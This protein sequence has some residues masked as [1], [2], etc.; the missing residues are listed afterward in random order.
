M[1]RYYVSL[2]SVSYDTRSQGLDTEIMPEEHKQKIYN[3]LVQQYGSFGIDRKVNNFIQLGKEPFSIIAF[4]NKFLQ[5]C[6]NAFVL[7]SYYPALTGICALGERILNHLVLKLR[8][9]YKNTTSYKNVY[10]KK[11]F[12]KWDHAIK[13]LEEWGIFID[14]K[15]FLAW[16][17]FQIIKVKR[18]SDNTDLQISS[19]VA[20]MFRRLCKIRNESI[21]FSNDLDFEDR[22]PTLRALQLLQ[23]IVAVQFGIE[24]PLR[25]WFIP[26]AKGYFIKKE[27]EDNPFI[28]EFFLPTCAFV[29]PNFKIEQ[30]GSN[31]KVNDPGPYDDTEISDE[32]FI[33]LLNYA[34]SSA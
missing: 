3:E 5:Q 13:A 14:E 32:Q 19:G 22:E 9:Y 26:G 12:D 15:V 24:G 25:S 2:F 4:H 33:Q 20:D 17:E 8:G 18:P 6:R 21:H 31:L 16:K 28:K 23:D 29:G 11:S 34:R 30:V 7:G 27:F 1:K 10:S